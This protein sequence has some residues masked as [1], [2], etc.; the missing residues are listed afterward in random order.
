MIDVIEHEADAGLDL[1]AGW[2]A[3][4]ELRIIRPYL[5]EPVPETPGTALIVLGG[6]M[7]AYADTA[8]PWLVGVRSL[9][10]AAVT[11]EVP[12]L[13]I[14]LGAQLLAAATGGAVQVNA[15]A[16]LEAG[17]VDV[18]WNG[19]AADDPLCAGQPVPFPSLAMHYDGIAAL[20]AGAVLLG[21][22]PRYP[23]QVFR[24]GAAAWGVQFHPEV[25]VAGFAGWCKDVAASDPGFD[26]AT[27]LPV[28]TARG[29]EVGTA[30]ERLARRF[31]EIVER[32][33]GHPGT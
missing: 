2:L 20:P 6:A 22:T 12:T 31:A 8:A 15:P 7:N 26:P 27:V 28:A 4:Q 19:A 17:V 16:G 14:C 1:F 23:H 30:G 33:P 29:G 13:G 3:D 10:A 24:V 25:S 18:T 9:L 5:G 32:T 21:S 11:R